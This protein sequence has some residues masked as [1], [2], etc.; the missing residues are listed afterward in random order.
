MAWSPLPELDTALPSVDGELLLNPA[1]DLRPVEA[2]VSDDDYA[3]ALASP[4][5]AQSRKIILTHEVRHMAAAIYDY[6]GGLLQSLYFDLPSVL[7]AGTVPSLYVCGY[8]WRRSCDVSSMQ[9]TR[10][11]E[12]ARSECDNQ[13]AIIIADGIGGLVARHYSARRGGEAKIRALFLIGSPTT[14]APRRYSD[15]VTSDGRA[16]MHPRAYGVYRE[17]APAPPSPPTTTADRPGCAHTREEHGLTMPHWTPAVGAVDPDGFLSN[18]FVDKH[19]I[20]DV[21][22]AELA[23][24]PGT[25]RF[26]EEK[27]QSFFEAPA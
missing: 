23:S 18:P 1:S 5:L 16:Y 13:P 11:M 26:I 27:I 12:Q 2:E 4:S 7:P 21:P 20:S 8:D 14:G 25:Y 9:L 22:Q 6:Y 19:A 17:E 3:S 15:L 10:V 24:D